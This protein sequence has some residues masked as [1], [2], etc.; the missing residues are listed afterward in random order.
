MQARQKTEVTAH[1]KQKKGQQQEKQ[2]IHTREDWWKTRFVTPLPERLERNKVYR[3]VTKNR[4]TGELLEDVGIEPKSQPE[5]YQYKLCSNPREDL[6][7]NIDTTFYYREAGPEKPY[8]AEI[9][10]PPRITQEA[11]KNGL[12]DGF[13]LDVTVRRKDGQTWDF[14]KRRMRDEAT[15]MVIEQKPF[16]LISSPPC[17]MFS[18]LRSG[19]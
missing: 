9:Y 5:D 16:M 14:S 8:I 1:G 2:Q 13:A 11:K 17:T 15:K 4:D 7:L 10:S 12:K 6:C 18:I 19:N 3:R